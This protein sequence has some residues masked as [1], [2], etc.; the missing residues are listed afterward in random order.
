MMLVLAGH[1]RGNPRLASRMM[2]V[3]QTS[4]RLAYVSMGLNGRSDLMQLPLPF[5][6]CWENN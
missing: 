4:P 1:K 3:W 6:Q 5:P 2:E